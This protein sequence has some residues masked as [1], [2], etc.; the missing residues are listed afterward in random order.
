MLK[1]NNIEYFGFVYIA[2]HFLQKLILDSKMILN[3]VM[4]IMIIL[5]TRNNNIRF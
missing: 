4:M 1:S 3:V 5:Y 2:F